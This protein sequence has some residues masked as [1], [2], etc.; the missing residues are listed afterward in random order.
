MSKQH[1]PEPTDKNEGPLSPGFPH[2]TRLFSAL[3]R[4]P[5]LNMAAKILAWSVLVIAIYTNLTVTDFAAAKQLNTFLGQRMTSFGSGKTSQAIL[6]AS[7]EQSN[8]KN[9]IHTTDDAGYTYWVEIVRAHPDYRDG[10]FMVATLAYQRGNIREAREYL[11][12]VSEI[13]PNYPGIPQL[14]E[15]LSEE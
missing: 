6:G 3:P 2:Y 10:Y 13:D 12:K 15:M 5:Q 8:N 4:L 1:S 9:Q 11:N 14:A 7:Q